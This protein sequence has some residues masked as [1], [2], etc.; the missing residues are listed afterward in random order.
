MCR[1]KHK[2]ITDEGKICCYN[3]KAPENAHASH[4]YCLS[5]EVYICTKCLN[6]SH[7]HCVL[8]WNTGDKA[9][10]DHKLCCNEHYKL[11]DLMLEGVCQDCNKFI[12]SKCIKNHKEHVCTRHQQLHGQWSIYNNIQRYNPG[13]TRQT[14]LCSGCHK[15]P[16]E[17]LNVN[18]Q[19]ELCAD[20]FESGKQPVEFAPKENNIYQGEHELC[21]IHGVLGEGRTLPVGDHCSVCNL[22][23]C[24]GCFK[25]HRRLYDY[26]SKHIEGSL[27]YCTYC[28]GDDMFPVVGY[29]LLSRVFKCAKCFKSKRQTSKTNSL[30][31]EVSRTIGKITGRADHF[32]C[33]EDLSK[34]ERKSCTEEVYCLV[35]KLIMCK[36]CFIKHQQEN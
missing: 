6:K 31:D 17:C 18:T 11:E 22:Y 24:V 1:K 5:H 7:K 36:T 32:Q 15:H 25:K 26:W 2:L 33:H 23:M 28:K 14:Q 3:C 35:C 29:D 16:I 4:A 21:Q 34:N 9:N 8:L 27:F 10:K 13:L 12:C 30:P 20:C 19:I